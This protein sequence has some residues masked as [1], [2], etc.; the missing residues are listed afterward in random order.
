ML[1][2]P[3]VRP[4]FSLLRRP[5]WLVFLLLPLALAGAHRERNRHL[6]T[7]PGQP[8]RPGQAAAA[9]PTP[10]RSGIAGPRYLAAAAPE[11]T[12]ITALVALGDREHRRHEFA[13]ALAAY[14]RAAAL[15]PRGD[16]WG[17]RGQRGQ[18]GQ[19]EKAARSAAAVDGRVLAAEA[20]IEILAGGGAPAEA[21]LEQALAVA[22]SAG[23]P[24]LRA[25]LLVGTASLAGR[26]G[27][28]G[29]ELQRLR[30][31]LAI[32][33]AARDTGGAVAALARLTL[34]LAKAGE[35]R[36]ALGAA[37]QALDLAWRS[38][39]PE[40]AAQAVTGL[41]AVQVWSSDYTGALRSYAD[42]LG[43]YQMAGDRLGMATAHNDLGAVYGWQGDADLAVAHLTACL[44]T[45][46]GS[47]A[48]AWT[49]NTLVNLTSA[50]VQRGDLAAAEDTARRGVALAERLGWTA[51]IAE[52]VSSLAEVDEARGDARA[53][54]AGFE[55]SL[56]L[57][58]QTGNRV[59]E[60]IDLQNLARVRQHQGAAVL[61]LT[62]ARRVRRES[63]ALG[64]DDYG[65][66]T[67]ATAGAALL[68]LGR[69]VQ[70]R[71]DLD[72]AIAAIERLR[73]QAADGV[74]A[75]QRFFEDKTEP[76]AAMAELSIEEGDVAA[77]FAYADRAKGR[78][79]LDTLR[80][81][82]LAGGQPAGAAPPRDDA[83]AGAGAVAAA[84]R[85]SGSWRDD[86]EDASAGAGPE[87]AM[88]AVLLRAR[89][90]SEDSVRRL[91][92]VPAPEPPPVA[93]PRPPSGAAL[94][95]LLGTGTM[96]VEFVVLEDRTYVF[97]LGGDESAAAP[98]VYRL[99]TGRLQLE[100]SVEAFRRQVAGRD[101]ET[102]AAGRALY[103]LLLAPAERRLQGCRALVI[104]PDGVLWNLP[105]QA[106]VLPDGRYVVDRQAVSYA[107]S[108]AVLPLLPGRAQAVRRAG[109]RDLLALGNPACRLH[110]TAQAPVVAYGGG[111]I[112][113]SLRW[114]AAPSPLPDAQLE[115]QA[116]A[117]LYG[118]RR[119]T[120]YTGRQAAES[121]LKAEAWNYRV[122]HIAA[123]GSL[124]DVHP[125]GSAIRLAW[126]DPDAAEDGQLE[127][128]E[129]SRLRLGADLVVLSGCET[130]R[131]RLGKGEGI[132]GLTWAFA[133]AGCPASVASQWRVDSAGTSRF[134]VAFHRALLG[135]AK[136]SEALR[137][138]ARTLLAEPL[139]AHPFYWAAF[140]LIGD[141]ART[142]FPAASAG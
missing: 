72:A 75:R 109:D 120:V 76:Y 128:R 11:A 12:D 57:R 31:A 40:D 25:R 118:E 55:R 43:L 6:A 101:L 141:G 50:L 32:C 137:T 117:K 138:A 54:L 84:D 66:Q 64:N 62:L 67:N 34:V 36:P 52:Q 63:R 110:R 13:R 10:A 73:L 82:D 95:R 1:T 26:R 42:A 18:G 69:R 108:A 106:L 123:H 59:G 90:N 4:R 122:L 17:Q 14:R 53:A 61:A 58:R 139:Y 125:M 39:D 41:A 112:P 136:A 83:P 5:A 60:A 92:V 2:P 111:A 15:V 47:G 45:M 114:P 103:D 132:I 113:T 9:A 16:R 129:V 119:S 46:T 80:G 51:Q 56:R 133:L 126:P 91:S 68:T 49:G 48:T 127:A 29:L 99:A 7:V 20:A 104:V 38:G 24:G 88:A 44:R 70:A 79:L 77:A 98:R 116:L 135:G 81:R 65:W 130:G 89:R 85:P 28:T 105:F 97:T 124:D 35:L 8:S 142:P 96:L 23:D 21:H 140:E 115:V 74:E 71:R 107:P 121:R 78:V 27:A 30:Q 22:E 134:M 33:T 86:D 102:R 94:V 93:V 131:G 100:K 37:R 19:V 3:A 87:A